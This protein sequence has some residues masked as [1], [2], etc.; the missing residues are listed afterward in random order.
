MVGNLSQDEIKHV[1]ASNILGRI[2]CTDG[3]SVYV[4][5]LNYLF[6]GQNI[7]C[8]SQVGKKVRMMQHNPNVCFEVDEMKSFTNWRSVIINGVYEELT[9]NE[10][11]WNAM[12]GFVDSLMR[13][14]ISETAHP[15][16]ELGRREH[17]RDGH[18]KT[19]VFKVVI[20]QMSG[21]YEGDHS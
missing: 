2:G 6:D 15:P 12:K 4:V 10:E 19:I 9:D 14:K 17:P 13:L 18:I 11:K 1:L 7:I 8:H 16:E 3:N 21:R 5:P 20:Q